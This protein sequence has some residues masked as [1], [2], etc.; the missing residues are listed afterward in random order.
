MS[1]KEYL[2]LL[3]IYLQNLP[4]F[5]VEDILSDY[6]EHFDIGISKGKSEEEISKEL[7]DPKEVA[8]NYK[9]NYKSS[10]SD[11]DYSRNVDYSNDNTRK[12]LITLLIVAFN[13]IVVLGPY[14]GLVGL[15][16][17]LYGISISLFVGGVVALFGSPLSFFT[18]LPAPH[19]LTSVSFSI[20]LIGLSILA[21]ILAVYLTK[22][23]YRL[24]LK[25]IN[26]NIELINRG[27]TFK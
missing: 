26:W 22:Q 19:I 3:R 27:G 5:E 8:N 2:E 18:A 7:G 16:M 23:F 24:T 4:I 6:E 9:T 15:L 13:L 25:Y 1:R 12:L 11:S 20:G 21:G 10:Y 14:L 17:G